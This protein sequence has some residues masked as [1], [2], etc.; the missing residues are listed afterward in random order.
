M[1]KIIAIGECVLDVIFRENR[2]E[3][4]APGGLIL[5]I[6]ANLGRRRIP[7]SFVGEAARDRVGDILVEALTAN[8]VDTASIDRYTDGVTPASLIFHNQGDDALS[9]VRYGRNNNDS[10]DVVWPRI[11]ADDILIFGGFYAIDPRVRPHLFEIVKHAAERKAIIVYVPGFAP[12]K[13]PRIT[14]VM[15]SILENF[16]IADIVV[17]RNR[18]LNNIFG[19]GDD[20]SAFK[21][22][23]SF[24]THDFINID[25]DNAKMRYYHDKDVCET[26]MDTC[27]NSFARSAGAIAGIVEALVDNGIT[28]R[29]IGCDTA[30]LMA[31]A[32]RLARETSRPV[33]EVMESLRRSGGYN[34]MDAANMSAILTAAASAGNQ[35]ATARDG[36]LP[37]K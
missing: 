26:S 36:L 31:A 33:A 23:I 30:E 6:A 15:P 25:R 7:V 18:D 1:R 2:P 16:E 10:F 35:A 27:G 37:P 24:Y 13:E 20:A 17:T 3:L 21:S 22:H 8:G 28:R 32:T 34:I 5:N 19:N 12:E 14:R 11:D 4:S 9:I 29:A